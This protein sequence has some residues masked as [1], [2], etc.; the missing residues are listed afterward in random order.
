MV[1]EQ[2]SREDLFGPAKTI[3]VRL[4]LEPA[5]HKD[6]RKAAAHENLSMASLAK[7]VILD[8]LRSLKGKP[9]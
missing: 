5:D 8:Y 1:E 4:Q 3:Q 6:L 2:P 9:K 7:R